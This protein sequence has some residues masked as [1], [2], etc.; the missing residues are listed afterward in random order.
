MPVSTSK[1][2]V[3]VVSS[4]YWRV[5]FNNPP[6]NLITPEAIHEFQ[7][8]VDQVESSEALREPRSVGPNQASRSQL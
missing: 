5:S 8:I 7:G 4:A 1:F 6:V 2:T 3:D